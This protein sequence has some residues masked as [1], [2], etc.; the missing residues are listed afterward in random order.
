MAIDRAEW[1]RADDAALALLGSGRFRDPA[2]RAAV[3]TLVAQARV[4]G[5]GDPRAALSVLLPVLT[6]LAAGLVLPRWAAR[7]H[8]VSALIFGAGD[9]GL[10][11]LR[12]SSRALVLA[13][14]LIVRHGDTDLLAL[15]AVA[16]LGG[17]AGPADPDLLARRFT[18]VEGDLAR[19]SAPVTRALVA[20]IGAERAVSIGARARA[21]HEI[22]AA[23]ALAQALGFERLCS[24]LDQLALRAPA[25]ASSGQT[26]SFEQ[27]APEYGPGQV[28]REPSQRRPK[29]DAQ[30]AQL[31]QREHDH[32]DQ[33]PND[34]EQP[35][36][37]P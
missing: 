19:A 2:A 20:T 31:G 36:H 11:D 30:D 13:R 1:S 25:S 12:R 9:C 33:H 16:A 37:P 23:R 24:R 21:L 8:V 26:V 34:H 29:A 6:D 15:S 27:A 18:M 28:V 35:E 4:L 10:V 22:A 17:G 32:G 5:Q 7:V 3:G 14:P